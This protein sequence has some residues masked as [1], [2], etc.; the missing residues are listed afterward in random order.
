MQ[1]DHRNKKRN[2]KRICEGIF[3]RQ[4]TSNWKTKCQVIEN[5]QLLSEGKINHLFTITLMHVYVLWRAAS[6]PLLIN[7]HV[8]PRLLIGS[9]VDLWT[10]FLW[11]H[12]WS[13]RHRTLGRINWIF[14]RELDGRIVPSLYLFLSLDLATVFGLLFQRHLASLRSEK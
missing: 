4:A 12:V 14:Q 8:P 6:V 9:G 11:A 2:K 1:S 7:R 5:K 10:V 13:W 3:M